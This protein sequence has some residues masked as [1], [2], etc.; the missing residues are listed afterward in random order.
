MAVR[1]LE[2]DAPGSQW[3]S[4]CQALYYP[5]ELSIPGLDSAWCSGIFQFGMEHAIHAAKTDRQVATALGRRI[6]HLRPDLR[7]RMAVAVPGHDSKIREVGFNPPDVI[8][9]ASGVYLYKWLIKSRITE[10]QKRLSA[11]RRPGN[12]S[13]AY[14]LRW[15]GDLCGASVWIIDDVL[16]TG[17][18][19]AECA[20][21]LRAAGA[22]SVHG[23]FAAYTADSRSKR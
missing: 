12:V 23:V 13:G 2:C 10:S 8:A 5:F 22:K 3:C 15:R 21:V 17:A 20:R 16:T 11:D 4:K 7:N 18:T 6:A 9:A 19:A 1:C 14:Q